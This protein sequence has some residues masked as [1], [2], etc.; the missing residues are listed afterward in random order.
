MKS[1][2][3]ELLKSLGLYSLIW[4]IAYLFYVFIRSYGVMEGVIQEW[5]E[6]PLSNYGIF[7]IIITMSVFSGIS[8]VL[9]NELLGGEFERDHPYGQMILFKAGFYMLSIL[10]MF[11]AMHAVFFIPGVYTGD[12][13]SL[14]D[15][16]MS[17]TAHMIMIYTVLII[18]F[19]SF[20]RMVDDKFGPGNLFKILLGYYYQPK[21]EERIIMFLDLKSSTSA[22]EKIGDLKY[23]KMIQEC[24]RD[25]TESVRAFQANIYQYVG[26]EVIL[27]W[28]TKEGVQNQ[29]CLRLFFHFQNLLDKK[30]AHYTKNYRWKPEFKAGIHWGNTVTTEVGFIK[31]D[32]AFHGD[33]LNTAARIQDKCNELQERLLISKKLEERFHGSIGKGFELVEYQDVD[34]KGKMDNQDIVGVRLND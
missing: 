31:K 26:D 25:I 3:R 30:E 32:I 24:F 7:L 21:S 20:V 16:Y 27:V 18:V 34:L 5:V 1:N 4:L 9:G 29:N 12:V 11:G 10:L 15:L 13:P 22:A 17:K 28:T 19:I 6:D 14:L 23:S 2:V 8:M 33:V